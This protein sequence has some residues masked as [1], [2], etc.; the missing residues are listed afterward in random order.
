MPEPPTTF[1]CYYAAPADSDV[2]FHRGTATDVPDAAQ[3]SVLPE[4]GGAAVTLPR[5]AV[6]P[7][8]ETDETASDNAQLT[9]LNEAGL[10]ANLMRRYDADSIYTYTGTVLHAL[11]PY[12]RMPALYDEA[13]RDAYRGKALGVMPPHVYAVAD[14]ARRMIVSERKDQSIVVSGESGAGKTESCRAIVEH[15]GAGPEDARPS[16]RHPLSPPP[17]RP[18]RGSPHPGGATACPL[19]HIQV[20]RSPLPPRRGRPCVVDAGGQPGARGVRL[21]GDRAQPQLLPLRQADADLDLA[22]LERA[23]PVRCRT[24]L[25]RPPHTPA[26]GPGRMSEAVSQKRH[27]RSPPKSRIRTAGDP[28]TS[29]LSV[30]DSADRRIPSSDP[31]ASLGHRTPGAPTQSAVSPLS[32]VD[33]ASISIWRPQRAL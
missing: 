1:A 10:L 20:P 16:L 2:P 26:C 21:R 27:W 19:V 29:S 15:A 9:H 4:A 8:H 30:S 28:G 17:A 3:L 13:T 14:R 32:R 22:R 23:Q 31:G 24:P 6:F 33:P 25:L 18:V 7:R 11:N 5:E 12:K